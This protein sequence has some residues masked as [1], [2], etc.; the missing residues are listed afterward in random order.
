VVT[1]ADGVANTFSLGVA[2]RRR[3]EIMIGKNVPLSVPAPGGSAPAPPGPRQDVGLKISAEVD[4]NGE[5]II[6][7]V[8]VESSAFDPPSSIRKL[9]ASAEVLA[10]P[11]KQTSVIKLDDDHKHFEVTVVA[12]P[13]P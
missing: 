5:D 1:S 13:L 10:L 12:T 11:G 4:P 7:H 8:N 6:V 9:V 2:E 3:G